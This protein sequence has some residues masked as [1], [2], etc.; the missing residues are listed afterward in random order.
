MRVGIQCHVPGRGAES[1]SVSSGVLLMPFSSEVLLCVKPGFRLGLADVA[2]PV[3]DE[4]LPGCSLRG[5]RVRFHSYIGVFSFALLSVWGVLLSLWRFGSGVLGGL[6]LHF[7]GAEGGDALWV[8]LLLLD[9]FLEELGWSDVRVG[10]ALLW[11]AWARLLGAL[12][13]RVL[14]RV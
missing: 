10:A 3:L 14:V 1:P 6:V 13:C 4:L 8:Q 9:H 2:P 11:L 7:E 5:E 12:L